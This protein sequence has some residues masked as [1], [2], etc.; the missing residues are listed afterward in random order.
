MK[1]K[2]SL[3][4]GVCAV[5]LALS[6]TG[7]EQ[8]SEAPPGANP[9]ALTG[10]VTID[11]TI[12]KVGDTLT[13]A[14]AGGNGSGTATWQWLAD[15]AA[16]SGANNDTYVVV[17]DDLDK[18]LSARVSYSRQSGS[19]TSNPTSAVQA[20][21]PIIH[22]HD[23][24]EWTGTTVPEIEMRICKT[25]TSHQ[26]HRLTGTDRFTFE[27][28]GMTAYR[29]RQGTVDSGEVII[30]AYYR[31][32]AN[33][34]FL[35][36]TEIGSAS[37]FYSGGA[38]YNTSISAITIPESVTSI[39]SYAFAGNI[40]NPMA[41]TTVTF[42]EGSQLTSIGDNAFEYCRSLENISIP[43]G[44]TSIGNSAFSWCS[45]LESI[46]IPEGITSISNN[47]FEYCS[48]LE[49]ISIPA[50]V[51]SIGNSAFIGCESLE[52]ISIP[53][54]VTSIGNS[55]F[56]GCSSLIGITIPDSV[57]TIGNNAFSNCAGLTSIGIP[58]SVTSI[59][60]AAFSGCESLTS[61]SIPAGVTSIGMVAFRNCTSLT[62]ISIPEGVTSIGES[63]FSGCE[64]LANINIPAGIT[65][66]GIS[67]FQNCTSLTSISIPESVTSIGMTAFSGCTNLI[68]ISIPAGVTS[69]NMYTFRNCGLIS[70]SIPASV[71]SIDTGAFEGCTSLTGINIP[72][73]VTS[74]GSS[75]FYRCTRLTSVV[76]AAGSAISSA[77]F[78]N[79]AFPEGNNGTGGNNLKTAYLAAGGGAGIY[80]RATNGEVWTKQ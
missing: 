52:S 60:Q 44:V 62:S 74:I 8:P 39:G 1:T 67:T 13:A 27:A 58:A 56:E 50:G 68:N 7:C 35:P 14:Y 57:E 22:V 61:I 75:A 33:G 4:C 24:G 5:I 17:S 20:A 31:L 11:N 71:T 53:A 40:N 66:I 37:D 80:T 51:T 6:L 46:S 25:N 32:D 47:T 23:W 77:N 18:A 42:A 79:S 78:G 34:T 38:F 59:S 30:P 16:I 55:A 28:A 54:G 45:S 41:I 43:E 12:P 10:T 70:I 9:P 19:V 72:A 21:A 36:V 15:D 49:S 26:E 29:V 2:Q 65:S 64:S 69:I 48:S 63:A 73:G 76:F 3:V